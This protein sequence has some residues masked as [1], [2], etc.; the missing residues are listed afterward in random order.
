M[1]ADSQDS[2]CV[3]LMKLGIITNTCREVL[4]MFGPEIFSMMIKSDVSG[5]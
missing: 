4:P 3:H 5:A 1:S 2:A